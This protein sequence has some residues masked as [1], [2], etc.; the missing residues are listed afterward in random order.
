MAGD[1]TLLVRE[2]D[3]IDKHTLGIKWVDG[4]ESRWRLSHLRRRCPCASCIDEWTN[5]PILKPGDVD[6]NILATRVESVG[7]YALVINFTDGHTTG[8]YSFG[9]LRE[10]CQCAQCEPKP[11]GDGS[12]EGG[13]A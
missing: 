13:D 11:A 8:I 10:L 9:L 3:Q 6:E 7:R 5:E 12:A 2:I 4:H 1:R